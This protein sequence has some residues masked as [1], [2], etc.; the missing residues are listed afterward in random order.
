MV[1]VNDKLRIS[2]MLTREKVLSFSTEDFIEISFIYAQTHIIRNDKEITSRALSAF[3]SKEYI[4]NIF[5]I[6]IFL[7]NE[8]MNF[9]DAKFHL[10]NMYEN[11]SYVEKTEI[12]DEI[13]CLALE[14]ETALDIIYWDEIGQFINDTQILRIIQ[15]FRKIKERDNVSSGF[16]EIISMRYDEF[17]EFI[18]DIQDRVD[19][20]EI[21]LLILDEFDSLFLD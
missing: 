1:S 12:L 4:P 15:C 6:N 14:D 5:W 7:A 18:E 11:S 16:Y 17:E 21:S 10:K 9:D 3:P 13:T 20:N 2:K 8:D 19:E